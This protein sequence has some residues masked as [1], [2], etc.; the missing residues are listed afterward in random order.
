MKTRLTAALLMACTVV[1]AREWQSADGSKTV[2]AGFV[3]VKGGKLALSVAGKNAVFP[4]SSFAAEDQQFAKN[5]QVIA[6]T[7]AKLG[8]QSFEFAHPAEDGSGWIC[9]MALKTDPKAGGPKLFTGEAFFLV[10]KDA[11]AH[12]KGQRIENQTLFG[13]G[14][15]TYHPLVGDPAMVRAFSLEA[16]HAT[17]VWMDVMA[18]SGGDVAKQAPNVLEPDVEIAT[19]HGFGIVIGKGG[20][21]ATDPEIVK[22]GF[23]S[24]VIHHD[25]KDYPA[26]LIS[27]KDKEGADLKTPDVQIVTC[28]VPLEPA[29]IGTKKIIEVGQNVFAIGFE[30]NTGKKG[31]SSKATVTRGI[32]SR[33]GSN[34]SFQHDARLSP[35]NPGGYLVGEKGDVLGFFFQT[36][37]SGGSGRKSSSDDKPA[38]EALGSCVS[39]Q[40]ISKLLERIPGQSELRTSVTTEDMEANGKAL[41]ASSVLVLA[42][43]EINKPRKITPPKVAAPAANMPPGANPPPA[44][45]SLS[46]S[47]IRHSS[48]CRYYNAQYPCQP[49]EGQPCKVCGG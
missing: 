48:K 49:T 19:R 26:T 32:V 38:V 1:A 36:Q 47:G 24:L 7:A 6:E 31:F 11:F 18:A 27:P 4:L 8:P 10:T 23:K 2:D 44:G 35:E 39:T 40:A 20:L 46:K 21:V 42:T 45:W 33:F 28:A 41:L 5:A 3:A 37:I 43:F 12:Q 9:R 22:K 34:G 29:R 13:A 17:K 16:E 30:L 25:G 14:G 15:R